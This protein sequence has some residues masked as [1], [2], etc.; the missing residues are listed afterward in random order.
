MSHAGCYIIPL[1]CLNFVSRHTKIMSRQR[2]LHFPPF[3][4]SFLLVFSFFFQ[5]TPAKHKV[6][7]YSILWH[8]NRSKNFK[9]MPKNG[10]KID[11][12]K[13]HHLGGYGLEYMIEKHVFS[14][15]LA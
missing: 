10:L 8:K 2:L 13:T 11:E 14:N 12:F 5:I 6:D 9:N 3:F 7:E 4:A 15:V 1:A